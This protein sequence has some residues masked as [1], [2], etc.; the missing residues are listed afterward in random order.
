MVLSRVYSSMSDCSVLVVVW[1]E[2]GWLALS[3]CSR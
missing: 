3:P 1:Q 2:R